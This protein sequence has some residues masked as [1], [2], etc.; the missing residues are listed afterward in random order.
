MTYS[1]VA[2][3]QDDNQVKIIENSF[4]EEATLSY[5]TFNAN[6]VTDVGLPVN[7]S[8][9]EDTICALKCIVGQSMADVI[10]QRQTIAWPFKLVEG[11]SGPLVEVHGTKITP[12]VVLAM[13]FQE[14]KTQAEK[15]LNM[16]VMK[17]IIAVPLHYNDRQKAATL[18]A[19]KLAGFEQCSL[20]CEPIAAAIAYKRQGL[21]ENA[22]KLLVFDMG[23]CMVDLTILEV[24][25]RNGSFEVLH[26]DCDHQLGSVDLDINMTKYCGEEFQRQYGVNA[27]DDMDPR[28]G[29]TAIQRYR[30]VQKRCREAKMNFIMKSSIFI[31]FS[32]F[33]RGNGLSV[34]ITR[35]IF[36]EINAAVFQ[37]IITVVDRALR[38]AA[39]RKGEIDDILLVGG[40]TRIP[41]I[42][43]MLRQYFNGKALNH[44]VPPECAVVYGAA[45]HSATL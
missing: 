4:G 35:K 28:D 32:S 17:A 1:R 16:P 26:V 11:E 13:L 30:R 37:R 22:R 9:P 15:Y 12:E 24:D 38:T 27:F 8:N 10:L 39:I 23:H 42:H 31:D 40:T 21:R 25:H 33:F 6:G 2:V 18:K 36:K 3:L 7:P 20:L 19:G 5:L 29:D 41:T 34:C 45:I 43:N 14:L 44:S